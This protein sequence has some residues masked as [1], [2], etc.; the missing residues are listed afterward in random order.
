M[1]GGLLNKLKN[2]DKSPTEDSQNN[3]EF[4][5]FLSIFIIYIF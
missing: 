2:F 4:P 3:C 5:V 1:F